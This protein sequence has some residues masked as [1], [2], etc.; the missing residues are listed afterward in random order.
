M[1]RK[2]VVFF[3]DTAEEET[4]DGHILSFLL[5]FSQMKNST[6]VEDLPEN[7]SVCFVFDN[8]FWEE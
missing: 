4:D 3:S 5:L 1:V 7:C 6:K 8:G 2:A